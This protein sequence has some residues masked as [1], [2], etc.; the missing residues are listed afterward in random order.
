MKRFSPALV[1]GALLVLG[2]RTARADEFPSWIQSVIV[3]TGASVLESFSWGGMLT[4]SPYLLA[5]YGFDGAHLTTGALWS[6]AMTNPVSQTDVQLFSPHIAVSPG[7]MY[8]IGVTGSA[9]IYLDDVYL[10]GQ[11][12]AAQ[13]GGYQ[14]LFGG[15]DMR[16]FSVAFDTTTTP[17]PASLALLA[18][19]LIGIAFVRRRRTTAP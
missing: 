19:G 18:T 7:T 1:I 4:S 2:T 11:V 15:K 12:Y 10:N 3:P 9:A 13:V 8:G 16:A 5:L 17:E 14:A 6:Q